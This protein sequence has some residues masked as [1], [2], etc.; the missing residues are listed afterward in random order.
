MTVFN[1]FVTTT[2]KGYCTLIT[3][4]LHGT[5]PFLRSY[6]SLTYSKNLSPFIEAESSL[7][8]SQEQKMYSL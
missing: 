4:Q 6:Q 3:A 5:Q 2:D 8:C 1:F 7:S